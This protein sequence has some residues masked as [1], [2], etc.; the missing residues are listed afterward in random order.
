MSEVSSATKYFRTGEGPTNRSHT[1]AHVCKDEVATAIVTMRTDKTGLLDI[2]DTYREPHTHSHPHIAH[3]PPPCRDCSFEVG[4][5]AV[6]LGETITV[7]TILKNN[8]A[9]QHTVDGRVVCHTVDYSGRTVRRFASMQ[10]TG[11]VSPGQSKLFIHH[12]L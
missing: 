3:F 7:V 12:R 6:R 5:E 2:S 10:F 1:L 9:L 11:V 4:C 8:G